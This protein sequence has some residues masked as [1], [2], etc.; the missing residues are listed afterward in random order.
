AKILRLPYPGGPLIHKYAQ[1]GNTDAYKLTETQIPELNFSFSGLKTAILYMVQAEE[2]KN[3]NFL[4]ENIA[5]VCASVQQRIVSILL[6]K[7]KKAVK[8][9]GVGDIA[10]AGGVSANSGLRSEEHTSELQ[11]RE[12]LVC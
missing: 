7:L 5:D 1:E 3:P 10:I 2:K 11:S 4:A 8:Q 12:N 9:T 6:N